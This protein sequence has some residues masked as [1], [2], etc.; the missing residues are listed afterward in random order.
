MKTKQRENVILF[1]SETKFKIV[2]I[3]FTLYTR[4]IKREQS[5]IKYY[6]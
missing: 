6:F 4:A 3:K 2:Y 1:S 5:N